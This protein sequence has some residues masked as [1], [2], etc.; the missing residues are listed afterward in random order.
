ME[1]GAVVEAKLELVPKAI[2]GAGVLMLLPKPPP[3]P[4]PPPNGFAGDG[5]ICCDATILFPNGEEPKAGA[6]GAGTG[7]WRLDD[8]PNVMTGNPGAAEGVDDPKP[9]VPPGDTAGTAVPKGLFA[10]GAGGAPNGAA[11]GGAP[12]GLLLLIPAPKPP[13]PAM[14]ALL[15]Q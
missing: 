1:F 8:A 4:P 9:K 11:G 15:F 12:N 10:A 7:F 3:P 13:N 14:S 6:A 5:A 2:A